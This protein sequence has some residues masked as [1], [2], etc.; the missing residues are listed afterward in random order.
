MAKIKDI[1]Q[2]LELKI[3]ALYDIETQIEKALPKMAMAATSAELQEG[4]LLHL[5]QTKEQIARLEEAFALLE[6]KPKKLRCE[7]IR[8]IIE[9]G[10]W[11]LKQ[12]AA[13]EVK[14]SMIATAARYVEHYEMAGYMSAIA[15]ARQLKLTGVEALLKQS[16]S[17]EEVTDKKLAKSAKQ[18]SEA[19]EKYPQTK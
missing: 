1:R 19:A 11:T 18:T 13:P 5:E 9:D 2:T 16:L 17:E 4:F 6:I 3:Q 10:E 12:S 15:Y 8:G 7:G 14:D